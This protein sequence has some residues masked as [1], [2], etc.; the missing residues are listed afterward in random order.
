METNLELE[1]IYKLS[2]TFTNEDNLLR[3]IKQLGLWLREDWQR[4]DA[5]II[6]DKLYNELMEQDGIFDKYE[7]LFK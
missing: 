2:I 6:F 3:F 7:K 4:D 5:Y 1:K